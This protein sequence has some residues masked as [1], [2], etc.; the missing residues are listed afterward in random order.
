VLITIVEEVAQEET[1]PW[2]RT[3]G[4]ES[5]DIIKPIAHA[6]AIGTPKSGKL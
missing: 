1:H 3:T 4:E 6:I 5:T 2:T